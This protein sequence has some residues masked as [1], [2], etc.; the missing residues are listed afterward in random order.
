[1]LEEGEVVLTG[2]AVKRDDLWFSFDFTKN[3]HL[4]LLRSLN[5]GLKSHPNED[6][7]MTREQGIAASISSATVAMRMV[8]VVMLLL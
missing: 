7:R 2:R 1:M 4:M 5:D 3:K 6:D 8:G